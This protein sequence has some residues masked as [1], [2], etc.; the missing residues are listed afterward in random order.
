MNG[1]TGKAPKFFGVKDNPLILSSTFESSVKK[2]FC[3]VNIFV[4]H[5]NE[6]WEG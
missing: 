4:Y 1:G 6:S 5:N 2:C 3:D